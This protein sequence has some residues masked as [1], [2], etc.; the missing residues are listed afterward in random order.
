MIGALTDYN[1]L[2]GIRHHMVP[3]ADGDGMTITRLQNVSPILDYNHFLRS[4]GSSHYKGEDGT[5]WHYAHLP[6]MVLETL[7][8]KFGPEIV[9]GDDVDDVVIKWIEREA[10]WLKVGEFNLA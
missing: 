2:S 1:P 10:P 7:I 3:D 8:Q 9:L 5:M 4:Q 6:I